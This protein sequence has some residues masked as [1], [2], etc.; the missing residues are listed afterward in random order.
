MK[1][2]NWYTPIYDT[3]IRVSSQ[4]TCHDFHQKI[5]AGYKI[6]ARM[7]YTARNNLLNWGFLADLI[8]INTLAAAVC[9][10]AEVAP[11]KY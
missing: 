10:E 9:A 3:I 11:F 4:M 8:D 1:F 7:N 5:L 6:P 2:I